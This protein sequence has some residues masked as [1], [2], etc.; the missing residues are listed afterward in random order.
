MG[1]DHNVALTVLQNHPHQWVRPGTNARLLSYLL[2]ALKGYAIAVRD[3]DGY[4]FHLAG[5]EKRP[6]KGS[7]GFAD[8][9]KSVGLATV[10]A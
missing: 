7:V 4:L 1:I 2:L 6:P 3:E 5:G 9:C 10:G 8:A